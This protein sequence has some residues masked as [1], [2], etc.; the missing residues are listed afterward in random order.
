MS[1][2]S[3][4][5]SQWFPSKN[6]MLL[7]V[8]CKTQPSHFPCLLWSSKV[9]AWRPCIRKCG[10]LYVFKRLWWAFVPAQTKVGENRYLFNWYLFL[11]C[12]Q[13]CCQTSYLF[14]YGG[15]LLKSYL[16]KHNIYQIKGES[17][18]KT[19][20]KYK[21]KALKLIRQ[22]V[23]LLYIGFEQDPVKF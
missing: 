5:G 13:C 19:Y 1:S 20:N 10:S 4:L 11:Y 6:R 7:N 23:D 22:T 3:F 16:K 15:R 14:N 21:L 17:L 8:L 18:I 2:R 12:C 9:E